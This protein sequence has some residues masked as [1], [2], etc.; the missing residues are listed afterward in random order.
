MKKIIVFASLIVL[1]SCVSNKKLT[2]VKTV[3]DSKLD[4][5][6]LTNQN[7]LNLKDLTYSKNIKGELDDN[8]S[9]K[10]TKL[11]EVQ[12]KKNQKEI[13]SL[14]NIKTQLY[15]KKLK[16]KTFN[17]IFTNLS[18][19]ENIDLS[20]AESIQFVEDILSKQMF[21]KFDS[22][23]FF[24]GGGY[25]IP[26]SKMQ[27]AIDF[28]TPAV[29]NLLSF[30]RDYPKF[31]IS[32]SIVSVGYADGQGFGEGPF[33]DFL[34]QSANKP[35]ATKEELNA[36]LSRL[37]AEEVSSIMMKIMEEKVKDLP[38][39]AKINTNFI[40]IGKGEEYPNKEITDYKTSDERRRIVVIFWNAI[41]E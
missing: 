24:E 17:S 30:S 6:I 38:N 36:E 5:A 26:E 14:S 27:E 33:V 25:K 12:K 29:D 37:R 4:K 13:D 1:N 41:P 32:S 35:E 15:S 23:S 16:V 7:L 9:E 2:E 31:K 22:A 3:V 34:K 8:S 39:E 21:I 28:F 40:K 11:I 10:I 19:E 18:S 20:V